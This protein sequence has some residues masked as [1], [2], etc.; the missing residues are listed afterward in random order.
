M[1]QITLTLPAA[2]ASEIRLLS[3]R[4]GRPESEIIGEALTSYLTQRRITRHR[5]SD[6]G[7]HLPCHVSDEDQY[8]S[9]LA[10]PYR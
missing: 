6:A 10:E 3:H 2:L 1:E 5:L 7:S 8:F 9:D 4:E